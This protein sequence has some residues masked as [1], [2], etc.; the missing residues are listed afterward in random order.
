MWGYQFN[1][2]QINNLFSQF[3]RTIYYIRVYHVYEILAKVS[4]FVKISILPKVQVIVS[5]NFVHLLLLRTK[6]VSFL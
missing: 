4:S 2:E 6:L 5:G 1:F 3:F